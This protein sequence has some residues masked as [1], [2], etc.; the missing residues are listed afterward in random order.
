MRRSAATALA[1]TLLAFC[2]CQQ[3]YQVKLELSVSR[4]QI[5]LPAQEGQTYLII[6]STTDWAIEGESSWVT[7]SVKS[8][9]GQGQTQ[10]NLN[11]SANTSLSREAL[12]TVIGAGKS[13]PVKVSQ[14]GLGADSY[15]FNFNP[16]SITVMKGA[17]S[18]NAA[19]VTDI[20][21]EG[22]SGISAKILYTDEESDPW[23]EDLSFDGSSMS[24]NVKENATGADRTATIT[25]T[26]PVAYWDTAPEATLWIT[27]REGSII[28]G[29]VPESLVLD[30]EGAQK[31]S[32]T[33]EPPY[34][35]EEFDYSV[36][37]SLDPV[38]DWLTEISFDQNS[39]TFSALPKVNYGDPRE[40]SL[41]FTLTWEGKVADT[42]TTRLVQGHTA[43]GSS[44]ADTSEDVEKDDEQTF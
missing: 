40:T 44:G 2:A 9:K 15:A 29:P 8:G 31:L 5:K 22:L 37:Y 43:Q 35:R 23:I 39:L 28:L 21:E 30:P 11:Y 13:I 10:V 14:E 27:Q 20:P 16:S 6:Y 19:I 41:T 36:S 32:F 38:P 3:P 25:A 24:F 42:K 4:N 17:A 7:P 26:L 1:A 34:S 18:L 12:F 33:L